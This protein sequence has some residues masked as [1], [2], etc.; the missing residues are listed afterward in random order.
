MGAAAS[1]VAGRR[2]ENIVPRPSSV[3]KLMEP[4]VAP[5]N[6]MHDGE[7]EAIAGWLGGKEWVE[8]LAL[9]VGR[10][11]GACIGNLQCY[12]RPAAAVRSV[13]TPSRSPIASDALVTRFMTTCRS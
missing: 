7:T 3:S 10:D 2:T 13:I 12:D 6:A 8:T 5:D 11:A 9:C 1:V 4:R